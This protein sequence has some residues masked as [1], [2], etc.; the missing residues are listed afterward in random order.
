MGLQDIKYNVIHVQVR[1]Y[2]HDKLTEILNETKLQ[3][4]E[5]TT[6]NENPK[7]AKEDQGIQAS[8]QNIIQQH[9]YDDYEADARMIVSMNVSANEIS[10]VN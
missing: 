2:I 1:D 3:P 10:L 9:L 8:D 7:E 5:E 6:E 4:L